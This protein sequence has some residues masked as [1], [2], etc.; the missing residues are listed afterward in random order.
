M[1]VELGDPVF[2]NMIMLGALCRLSDFPLEIG[3]LKEAL[4]QTFPASK[5]EINYR[6]LDMGGNLISDYG[7]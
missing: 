1:A 5:L 6:A 4:K 2:L 3:D 7:N